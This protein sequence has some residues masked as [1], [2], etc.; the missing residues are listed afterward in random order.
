MES[1][2]MPDGTAAAVMGQILIFASAEIPSQSSSGRCKNRDLTPTPA[3]PRR[4]GGWL[5]DRLLLRL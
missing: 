4:P 5:Q 1:H 3:S 2:L